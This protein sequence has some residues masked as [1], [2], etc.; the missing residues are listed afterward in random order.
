MP[1]RAGSACTRPGCRGVVHDGVC[2]VCGPLRTHTQRSHDARRGTAH[3]RGYGARW[4][5]VRE[6]VLATSPLCTEC[7]RQG[8]IT[9]ATDVHHVI[10]RR[11]GGPDALDNLQ[12]LCH[13]C[14]SRVTAHGG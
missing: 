14:H 12:P 2:S 13:A 10:A 4:R 5:R 1:R 7:S 6:V 9:P 3:Q 8:I 11:D